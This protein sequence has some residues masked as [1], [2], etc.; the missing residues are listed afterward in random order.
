MRT[1]RALGAIFAG[2]TATMV[3]T[4]TLAQQWPARSILV[5]SPFVAGTT[6]DL[7]A[8]LVLDHVGK[9]LGQPF[10]IENRPGGD[11]T[12]GVAAVVHAAPDGYTLLLSS[13]SMS[14]AAI[15]HKSLP[16]DALRDLEPV[17]MLGG[18]PSVLVAAPDKG[19]QSVADLVAAAKAKPGTLKFAS[20]GFGS[21][22]YFAGER[23]ALA[24]NVDVQHVPYRGPVEALTDLMAG[25]VDFYFV[26][27]PPA[28]P[29]IVQGKVAALAVTT[30]FRLAD[31]PDVPALVAA[32]G[33]SI[34]PYLFWCGLSAPANTPR[35]IV[36]RLNAA[37]GNV[38]S[39]AGIQ[40]RFR[41]MGVSPIPMRP[42]QY[43]KFFADDMAAMIQLGKDAHIAPTE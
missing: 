38:L 9:H 15:L 26:P 6:N 3:V 37:I 5:V 10:V 35:D 11:G 34:Q 14:S 13:S 12:T 27:I 23:L 7:I 41:G 4:A 33:F 36:D 30:P 20:V 42:E 32:A 40:I 24:A 19:F 25:R 31:L 22:S 16:Y 1:I 18:Q 28:K 29:L 39:D 2:V 43:G 21:A 17:A 8:D